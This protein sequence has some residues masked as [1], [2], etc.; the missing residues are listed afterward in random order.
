MANVSTQPPD[1]TSGA[2]RLRRYAPR[3]LLLLLF[4]AL[5]AWRLDLRGAVD[6]LASIDLRFVLPG[7]VAFTIS[8][9]VAAYRW[10]TFL[11]DRDRAPLTPLTGI[12]L[13]SNLA[14][15]VVPLRAG[16]LLRVELPNRRFGIPRPELASSV[17]VVESV[18]DGIAFAILF[19]AA[20]PFLELPPVW[21]PIFLVAGALALAAFIATIV[22]AHQDVHADYSRRPPVRWLPARWR[23][24]I[25]AAIP[26]FILG[27]DVLRRPRSGA[28]AIAIS[29][30]AWTVE[31][32]VYWFLARAF[33]LSLTPAEAIVITIA[34]NLI[35]SI[36]VTPWDFGPYEVVVAEAMVLLGAGLADASGFA[37]GSHLLLQLWIAITGFA[38]MAALG[39]RPAELIPGRS[40]P[41]DPP[42][43]PDPPPDPAA[44]P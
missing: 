4:L 30:G 21:R 26:P 36:P 20:L 24:R 1:R 12:F 10:R 19:L 14:N 38:A 17:F 23:D 33:G 31:V 42:R 28:V 32:G 43:P 15:A 41:T 8:K 37:I 9:V 40:R 39:L 18:L 13:L 29:V 44:S 34:A 7:L 11:V 5:M 6:R 35:V 3:L 27:T 16:D 25:A 2:S 22:L